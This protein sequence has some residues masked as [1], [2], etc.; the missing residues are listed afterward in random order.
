MNA[1]FAPA[2]KFSGK[3]PY[4]VKFLMVGGLMLLPP[5]TFGYLLASEHGLDHVGFACVAVSLAANLLVLYLFTGLYFSISQTVS[6]F[7]AAIAR[8]SKGD[9]GARVA[10]STAD[11]MGTVGKAFNEMG[12]E[13]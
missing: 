10:V 4:R 9:L 11:E 7:A 5:L 1:I 8:F 13:V 3:L 2:V 6:S 12:K